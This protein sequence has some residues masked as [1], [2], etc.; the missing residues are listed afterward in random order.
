MKIR[1][2]AELKK[3][4]EQVVN[5]PLVAPRLHQFN[6]MKTAFLG[7][8]GVF[9]ETDPTV[10]WTLVSES[11]FRSQMQHIQE[12]FHCLSIDEAL[13]D[14]N[15]RR[16]KPAA[17]VTFDDG[18]ANN[19]E[20][21]LPILEEY[22][23]P[24]IIYI[25][26]GNVLDRELF[27]P[28][29]IWMV[30]RRASPVSIDLSEVGSPLSRYDLPR[31]NGTFVEEIMRLLED[32]KKI[33]PGLR[34]GVVVSIAEK[35]NTG[36]GSLP[37]YPLSEG[38]TFTPLTAEQVAIL[39][40]HPLIT[41]GAHTHCHNLLDQ[42]PLQQAEKTIIQSKRILEDITGTAIQHFA[43]PNGNFNDSIV[44]IVKAAGFRS[45]A[46]FDTGFFLSGDDPFRIR[47]FGI[48]VDTSLST[49]TAMLTGIFLMKNWKG[50]L[51]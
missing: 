16:S 48:A 38:H 6:R 18:Y 1:Y 14:N 2:R 15:S 23:I 40:R 49:F 43:Y 9:P 11:S 51:Q 34:K 29:V 30:A 17:V 33:P 36:S 12:W 24:A 41:I 20:L 32:V 27:W 42:I 37:P 26:T 8:H 25:T 5:S 4:I 28:D 31:D 44:R 35:L 39:A 47:R 3:R 7:Y 45:A 22:G 13:T 21:A 50:L 19:L 10:A 46:T